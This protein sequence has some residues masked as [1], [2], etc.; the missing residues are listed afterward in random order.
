VREASVECEARQGLSARSVTPQVLDRQKTTIQHSYCTL[1]CWFFAYQSL[2]IKKEPLC[3]S[4][5]TIAIENLEKKSG[6]KRLFDQ[7]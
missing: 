3:F 2:D 1:C 4:K 7:T 5:D 6:H